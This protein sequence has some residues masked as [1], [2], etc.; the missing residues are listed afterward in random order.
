MPH[1]LHVHHGY[2]EM[3]PVATL[4]RAHMCIRC[5]SHSLRVLRKAH[6][7]GLVVRLGRAH[8]CVAC[9]S[10]SLR[11]LA[12]QGSYKLCKRASCLTC[13]P[14]ML[15]DGARGKAGQGSF[16]LSVYFMWRM[17]LTFLECASSGPQDEARGE[18][19]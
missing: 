15:G 19:G 3:G 10:H 8:M 9:S 11:V 17:R 14:W 12:R 6:K 7:M 13:A 5:A 1:A 16:V 2:Y 18:A 4:G